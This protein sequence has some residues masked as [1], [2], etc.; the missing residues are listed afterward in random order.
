MVGNLVVHRLGFGASGNC[1][2]A[3]LPKSINRS[4][5]MNVDEVI[6]AIGDTDTLFAD[7]KAFAS[8]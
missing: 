5:G 8:V 3:E 1:Y 7:A 2:P 6:S 4:L